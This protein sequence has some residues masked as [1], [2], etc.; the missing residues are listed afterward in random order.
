MDAILKHESVISLSFQNELLENPVEAALTELK[1]NK[2]LTDMLKKCGIDWTNKKLYLWVKA[3]A[4]I[5]L[6]PAGSSKDARVKYAIAEEEMGDVLG[7]D[8]GKIKSY[9]MGIVNTIKNHE[10]KGIGCDVDKLLETDRHVFATMGPT[11]Q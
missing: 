3:L 1:G 2:A 6:T 9:I 5:A 7:K 10:A 4:E 8:F 11:L